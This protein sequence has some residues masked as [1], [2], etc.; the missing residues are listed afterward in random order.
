[1]ANPVP[2]QDELVWVGST[3]SVFTVPMYRIAG[4]YAPA[5]GEFSTRTFLMPHEPMWVNVDARW[6]GRLNNS[7]LGGGCD[8]G[9][10]AYFYANVLDADTGKEIPEYGVD[11]AQPAMDVDLLQMQL[12]LRGKGDVITTSGLSGP[13]VRL[14][15]HFRDAT[16]FAVGAG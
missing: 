13:H 12:Q 6:H 10:A 8:E 9:C 15:I 4:P 2:Y 11:H 7:Y 5:N 14:R 1:M 3:G 16:V